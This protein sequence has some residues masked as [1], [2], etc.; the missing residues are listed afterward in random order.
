MVIQMHGI[1]VRTPGKFWAEHREGARNW[2]A[3]GLLLAAWNASD[4]ATSLLVSTHSVKKYSS[5]SHVSVTS[6]RDRDGR[7]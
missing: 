2:L 3:L 7:L 6:I 1:V 4:D 5:P